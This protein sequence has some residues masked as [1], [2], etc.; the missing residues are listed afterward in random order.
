M[1]SPLTSSPDGRQCMQ[2]AWISELPKSLGPSNSCHPVLPGLLRVPGSV[3][4]HCSFFDKCQGFCEDASLLWFLEQCPDYR[5]YTTGSEQEEQMEDCC[6]SQIQTVG[7]ISQRNKHILAKQS[8]FFHWESY[9]FIYGE[10]TFRR[11][12]GL[13]FNNITRQKSTWIY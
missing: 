5:K 2:S 6:T 10:L 8:G 7:N 1:K 11:H 9:L 12:F 4:P 3:A 13:I